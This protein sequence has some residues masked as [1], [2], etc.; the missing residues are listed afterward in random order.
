M[1]AGEA[2]VT[3][4]YGDWGEV[5]PDGDV[6]PFSTINPK[7]AGGARVNRKHHFVSV[8]YMDGFTDERGRIQVYRLGADVRRFCL[9]RSRHN[10]ILRR[11]QWA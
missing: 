5:P 6:V 2:P 10:D 8:T 1:G 4:Y 9:A 3:T 7:R 11:R